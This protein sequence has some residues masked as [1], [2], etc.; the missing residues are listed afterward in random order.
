MN[1]VLVMRK[2][3]AKWAL[4]LLTIYHK[5]YCGK[6]VK[7]CNRKRVLRQFIIP[8]SSRNNRF[9]RRVVDEKNYGAMSANKGLATGFWDARCIIHID[10]CQQERI[11]EEE[12]YANI[13]NRFK[14]N[15]RKQQT[16]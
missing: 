7:E 5:H 8:N 16:H 14:D 6:I 13:L 2:L 3:S 1:D 10:Y 4:R 15:L 9:L 11:I 12:I